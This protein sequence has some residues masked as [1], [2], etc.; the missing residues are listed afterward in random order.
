ML[1]KALTSLL[2]EDRITAASLLYSTI[3]RSLRPVVCL[4]TSAYG[5]SPKTHTRTVD[6]WCNR[7]REDMA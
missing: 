5:V 4:P 2:S 1:S 3:G 7:A 6:L